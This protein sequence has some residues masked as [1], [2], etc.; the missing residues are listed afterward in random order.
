MTQ[1]FNSNTSN[2][3]Y[4]TFLLARSNLGM[5]DGGIFTISETDPAWSEVHNQSKVPIA[6][7]L[8]QWVGLMDGVRVNGKNF[9]G[10]GTL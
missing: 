9:T 6:Q 1:I 3:S 7:G 2:P 4:I 10:N 8:N 5:S